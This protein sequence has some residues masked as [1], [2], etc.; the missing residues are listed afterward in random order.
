MKNRNF[1]LFIVMF[2][3][4]LFVNNSYAQ[5]AFSNEDFKIIASDGSMEDQFGSSISIDSGVIAV[6]T[7]FDISSVLN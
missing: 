6:G 1:T 3:C 5:D 7:P 2:V 4:N